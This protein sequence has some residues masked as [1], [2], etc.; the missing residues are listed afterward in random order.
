M[1]LLEREIEAEHPL[2]NPR[3]LRLQQ[4]EH[5]FPRASSIT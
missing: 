2:A 4:A 1:T 5:R 3:F